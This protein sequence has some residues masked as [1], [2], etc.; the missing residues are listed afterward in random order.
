[1]R[2]PFTAQYLVTVS[3][4]AVATGVLSYVYASGALNVA[5]LVL[6][7]YALHLIALRVRLREFVSGKFMMK[8]LKAQH[9]AEIESMRE[10]LELDRREIDNRATELKK[11]V[12][13]AEEQWGTLRQMIRGQVGG[14]ANV[15]G[16][17]NVR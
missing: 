11:R 6:G 4:L 3:L 8:H 15:P 12:A 13:A 14:E 7:V 16:A 9:L 1:M 10:K 2:V 5:A 17:A